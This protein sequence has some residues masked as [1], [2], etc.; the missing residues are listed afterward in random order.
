MADLWL[1]SPERLGDSICNLKEQKGIPS[2]ICTKKIQN[3]STNIYVRAIFPLWGCVIPLKTPWDKRGSLW[4][5]FLPKESKIGQEKPELRSP[6][7][8]A[9]FHWEAHETKGDTLVLICTK[10]IQKCSKN[11]WVTA[12]HS[13]RG[14]V[15][16][17][18]STWDKTGSFVVHLY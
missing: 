16:P 6:W 14:W 15:I 2:F 12:I 9:R 4:C 1:F 3:W 11:G 18:R 7:E 10:K 8:V 17:L 13:L 5:S